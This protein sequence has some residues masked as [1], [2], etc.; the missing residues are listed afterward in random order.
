MNVFLQR[1]HP[2][3]R[4]PSECLESACTCHD[5]FQVGQVGL[6]RKRIAE[7]GGVQYDLVGVVH[8]IADVS[9][10]GHYVA[11]VKSTD[12]GWLHCDDKTVFKVAVVCLL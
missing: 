11:D 8:H 10:S 7:L 6:S 2:T 9:T 1:L 5:S 3:S 4:S 12:G